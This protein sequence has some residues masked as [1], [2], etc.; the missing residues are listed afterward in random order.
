DAVDYW[1]TGRTPHTGAGPRPG[2]FF[3]AL[4]EF[5]PICER[6][7]TLCERALRRLHEIKRVHEERER[8]MRK[9]R[10]TAAEIEKIHR[11]RAFLRT[12]A[13]LRHTNA[14]RPPRHVEFS[15]DQREQLLTR[16]S[17][18]QKGAAP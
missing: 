18:G 4:A 16:M 2:V 17:K 10:V 12:E 14:R 8:A 7:L 6:M 1:V 11:N 3:P 9:T 13:S 15:D 5:F